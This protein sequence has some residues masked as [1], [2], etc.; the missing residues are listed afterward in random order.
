MMKALILVD[1]NGTECLTG[2][3]AYEI[4]KEEL[5]EILHPMYC[6]MKMEI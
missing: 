2:D 1:N 3:E 5:G 6:G 4:L